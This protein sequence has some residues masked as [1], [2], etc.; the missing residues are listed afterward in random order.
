MSSSLRSD[1]GRFSRFPESARCVQPFDG[2][3]VEAEFFQDF[4]V[5]FADFRGPF[6]RDFDH[7]VY[8]NRAADC[9][10]QIATR[11]L[12]RDDDIVLPQL[13]VVDHF[14]GSTHDAIREVSLVEDFL[15]VRHRLCGESCVQNSREFTRIGDGGAGERGQNGR[16][17]GT[18]AAVTRWL[19]VAAAG[20]RFGVAFQS[21][22]FSSACA[23]SAR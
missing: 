5:V 16:K 18:G 15:P 9:E 11:A 6:S 23:L 7:A 3:V 13:R 1:S 12:D 8:L 2:N 21:G 20:P 22:W 17:K 10:I 19:R 4:V 14:G